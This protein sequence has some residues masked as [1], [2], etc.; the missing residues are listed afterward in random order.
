M[1]FA[2]LNVGIAHDTLDD[3]SFPSVGDRFDFEHAVYRPTLGG[4]TDGTITNVSLDKAWSSGT[5]R[6]LL[7]GRFQLTQDN[8]DILQTSSALGGL[9]NLSGFTERELTGDQLAL[10]RGIYYRR[11]GNSSRL[12]SSPYYFGGSIEAGNVWQ[13]RDDIGHDL[14]SAGSLFFAVD[15][16][17]GPVFLGYGRADTGDQSFYLN[18][19]SLLRPRL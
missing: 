4:E 5:H 2:A 6:L 16:F 17:I 9:T 7:G 1:E 11:L 13:D 18:L 12:Y 10:V 3:A 15:T 19:G 8:P 14:I